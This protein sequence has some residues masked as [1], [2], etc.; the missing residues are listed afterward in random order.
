MTRRDLSRFV[1]LFTWLD[2]QF[3][4]LD[5][6]RTTSR[7]EGGVNAAMRRMLNANRGLSEPHMKTAVE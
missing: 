7:L 5:I 1:D 2:P 4:G 3:A 6:Q